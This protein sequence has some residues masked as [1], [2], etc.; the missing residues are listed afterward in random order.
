MNRIDNYER[1]YLGESLKMPDAASRIDELWKAILNKGT[2]PFEPVTRVEKY[3][4]KMIDS[5]IE[6]PSP[7]TRLEEILNAICKGEKVD[8][9][10]K[11]ACK[12]EYLKY[13]YEQVCGENM[14]V[15]NTKPTK[16][17]ISYNG[18]T[19]T[20][21]GDMSDGATWWAQKYNS[22]PV[23]IGDTVTLRY[24]YI[25]GSATGNG[26]EL[27]LCIPAEKD[28]TTGNA[29]KA[30]DGRFS[31]SSGDYNQDKVL[32]TTITALPKYFLMLVSGGVN[33]VFDNLTFEVSFEK[34]D[35][36]K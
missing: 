28:E 19:I 25:S 2:L 5:S 22:L 15:P 32:V 36:T 21:N 27:V 33:A 4:A 34:G 7:K 26:S 9:A 29:L 20:L 30:T 31:F 3:L 23:N 18:R 10:T 8:E 6:T 24:R 12:D 1:M 13:I 16:S 14:F 11:N 35:T 17:G